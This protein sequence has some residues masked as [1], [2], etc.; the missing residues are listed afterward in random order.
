MELNA[1][2]CV[3]RSWQPNDRNALMD[4]AND[5]E[6]WRNLTDRFPYPY[7]LEDADDWIARCNDEGE[8][9]LNLGIVVKGQVGGGI[10][11]E[12]LNHEKRHTANVGYWLA[13]GHWNHGIATAALGAFTAYALS[14]FDLERLQASVFEWNPASARVL[15]KCG[16]RLEGQLRRGIVKEG[17]LTDELVY[18]LLRT[19]LPIRPAD[20]SQPTA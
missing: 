16:Y 18:G 7:T 1:G 12:L 8:P 5:Y 19:E 9:P 10:G 17:K 11:L 13:Q 2:I 4:A 20:I 14:S 3:L 6:V 15:E